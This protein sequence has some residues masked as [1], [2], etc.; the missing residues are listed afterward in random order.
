M[1]TYNLKSIKN[2]L[3]I[4]LYLYIMKIEEYFT[5][6]MKHLL[7]IFLFEDIFGDKNLKMIFEKIAF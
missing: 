4:N 6:L 1:K 7:V 5:S 3:F 2:Y